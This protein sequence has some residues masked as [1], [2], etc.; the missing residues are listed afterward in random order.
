MSDSTPQTGPQI[1]A[2][3][4]VAR[5]DE[6]HRRSPLHRLV[7][8]FDRRVSPPLRFFLLV[9]GAAIFGI[10]TDNEYYQRVGFNTLYYAALA[11]GLNVV[12][13]WA[14]LLDLGYVA[15]FGLGAYAYGFLDS[16][17]FGLHWPTPATIVVVCIGCAVVGVLVSIPSRRLF[18][19][20]LAIITLFFGQIFYNVAGNWTT[21]T[22]GQNGLTNLDP[23]DFFGLHITTVRRYYYVA[24]VLFTV[25]VIILWL[26]NHSRTGRAWRSLREDQMAAQLLGIPVNSMKLLAFAFGAAVAGLTGTVFA[27]LEVNIF[28]NNFYLSVLITLYA[29]VILGGAG[30]MSG[31]M[32]GAFVIIVGLELL[33]TPDNARLLFYVGI[34]IGL[35][36]FLRPL[37]W[38]AI[39]VCGTIALGFAVNS[40]ATAA[41]PSGTKPTTFG[42]QNPTMSS[43]VVELTNPVRTGAWSYAILIAA[44]LCLT[45]LKGWVRKVA[46]IPTLYLAAFVWENVL[47]LNPAVTALIL[48][49]ALLISLMIVK[50][51]GLLGKARV[52]VI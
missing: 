46:L 17:K 14:G 43:W 41:W 45:L 49:G 42:G 18:G 16:P 37:K 47:V 13:G 11:L 9:A 12:V 38:L 35:A 51:T 36:L 3:E 10:A 34:G 30:S 24:L 32:L 1:G 31:V 29:I 44:V 5:Q 25:V 33:S 22:N 40:I 8:E 52:E 28:P 15:F 19:D 48:L 39:V 27:S 26:I 23:L 4:W 7:D 20:Y 2:D 21:I 50:P 6:R